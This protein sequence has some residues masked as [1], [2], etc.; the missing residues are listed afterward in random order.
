MKDAFSNSAF[1]AVEEFLNE[2]YS[3]Y[4]TSPKRYHELQKIAEAYGETIPKP[5]NAYRTRWI[6]HKLQT[7][8]AAL[9]H[10][11]LLK[12]YV[13]S[14]SQTDSQPKRRAQLIG[15]IK[16]LKNVSLPLSMSIYLD[17]LSPKCWLSLS[18]QEDLH[19]PV[20]AVRGV[21]EFTWTMAKLQILIENTLDSQDSIMTSY[22]KF[23]SEIVKKESEKEGKVPYFYQDVKFKKFQISNTNVRMSE[24]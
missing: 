7:M 20:K 2:I 4:Q 11:G 18:F 13:E 23:L 10:Y 15:F 19:D 6:D 12:S 24:Y 22:K 3:L 14:L 17:V 8:R 5:M 16:H 1:K 9:E 21:Q